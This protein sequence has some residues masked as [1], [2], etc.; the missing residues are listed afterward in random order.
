LEGTQ[1]G[2]EDSIK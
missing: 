2:L 1:K